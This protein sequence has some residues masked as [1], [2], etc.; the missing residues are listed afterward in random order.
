MTTR[1][2][3]ATNTVAGKLP[4]DTGGYSVSRSFQGLDLKNVSVLGP[5]VE[6][7]TNASVCANRLGAANA[8]FAHCL[9]RLRYPHDGSVPGFWIY[10]FDYIDHS[11][12]SR[13]RE[14]GEEPG[15]TQH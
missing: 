8:R 15:M 12:E 5:N 3:C 1:S 6:P 13:L 4:F 14:S 7:A 11:V 10:S 9:F 2:A